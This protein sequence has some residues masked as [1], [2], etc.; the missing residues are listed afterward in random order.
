MSSIQ[1]LENFIS[2]DEIEELLKIAK[3]TTDSEWALFNQEDLNGK[4]W[5][6]KRLMID[7]SKTAN[8]NSKLNSMWSSNDFTATNKLQRFFNGENLGPLTDS[9]HARIKRSIIIFLS[10]HDEVAGIEFPK[11]G[12]IIPA[13]KNFAVEYDAKIE[14]IIAAPTTESMYFIT[15]F[16]NTD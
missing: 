5:N 8:L 12:L 16:L 2:Q 13:T 4:F 1:I 10:S 14:Y 11:D 7:Q 9:E 6:G 3:T 15:V